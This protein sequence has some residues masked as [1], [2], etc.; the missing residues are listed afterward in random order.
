MTFASRAAVPAKGD[1]GGIRYSGHGSFVMRHCVV[2]YG[3]LGIEYRTSAHVVSPVVEDCVVGN[4]GGRGILIYGEGGA[5]LTAAVSGNEV[6]GN[7]WKVCHARELSRR[8]R[9]GQVN[10]SATGP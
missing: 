8:R 4:N 1:W 3:S 7:D 9:R 6:Y 10:R 5:D 2:E